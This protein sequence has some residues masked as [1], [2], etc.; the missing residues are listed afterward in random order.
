MIN[1]H[2]FINNVKGINTEIK[3]VIALTFLFIWFV[4]GSASQTPLCDRILCDRILRDRI[5]RDRIFNPAWSVVA[6]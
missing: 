5:L 3:A 4:R 2:T 6:P 1:H